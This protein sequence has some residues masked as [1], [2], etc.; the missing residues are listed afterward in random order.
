MLSEVLHACNL[1][2]RKL[3][4]TP[5]D[6]KS[7]TS[8][9]CIVRLSSNK[10]K[11]QPNSEDESW[12]RG[13]AGLPPFTSWPSALHLTFLLWRGLLLN[14]LMGS[15]VRITESYGLEVVS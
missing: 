13:G 6:H 11:N 15:S 4:T 1:A 5:E 10:N 9:G 8:L 12:G 3:I 14:P 2:L 7:E